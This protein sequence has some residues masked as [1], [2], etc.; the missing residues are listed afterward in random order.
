[1]MTASLIMWLNSTP[2]L[3]PDGL[4]CMMNQQ[5][6]VLEWRN[7]YVRFRYVMTAL[8]G[9]VVTYLGIGAMDGAWAQDDPL[10]QV[11]LV[12]YIRSQTTLPLFDTVIS[13]TNVNDTNCPVTIVWKANNSTELCTTESTLQPNQTQHHCSSQKPEDDRITTMCDAVCNRP[14]NSMEGHAVIQTVGSCG[15]RFGVDAKV[16]SAIIIRS[17]DRIIETKNIGFHSVR[18]YRFDGLNLID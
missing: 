17:L 9:F 13:I 5:K 18:V 8:L 16:F 14:T 4:E 7:L 15:V 3:L 2:Y 10:Q 12:P 6:S 1:M 11:F